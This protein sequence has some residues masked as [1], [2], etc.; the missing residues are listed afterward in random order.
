MRLLVAC[1]I[2]AFAC[3]VPAY[4]DSTRPVQGELM[5]AQP[6]NN[7]RLDALEQK[8]T[9]LQAQVAQLQQ[10]L[11]QADAAT[12][13][14]FFDDRFRLTAL[15]ASEKMG[16]TTSQLS[17]QLNALMQRVSSVEA[18][19]TGVEGRATNIEGNVGNLTSSLN[20]LS[21]KFAT[22]TH[23]YGKTT[24]AWSTANGLTQ[25]KVAQPTQTSVP[26]GQ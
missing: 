10:Q 25:I 21:N 17:Q 15:E 5:Q 2:L 3:A 11:A 14:G 22:H 18:R 9:Q 16:G 8:V 6:Y 13:K 7:A 26:D 23:T 24:F 4:A 19:T 20:A 12:S 1:A